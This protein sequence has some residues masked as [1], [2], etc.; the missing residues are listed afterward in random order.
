MARVPGEAA[1]SKE[2]TV[3]AQQNLDPRRG[4]TA[5]LQYIVSIVAAILT[6][7]TMANRATLPGGALVNGK[8][9]LPG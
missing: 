1:M 7:F 9:T 8:T 3:S 6:V 4:C 2:A 5:G